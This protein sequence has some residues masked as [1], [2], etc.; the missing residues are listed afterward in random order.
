[1]YPILPADKKILVKDLKLGVCN[2]VEYDKLIIATG[3]A[4]F[5][6]DIKNTG[7]KNIFTLRTL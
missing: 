6:P 5:I 7:L 1:M 4:P 3:A 2:F